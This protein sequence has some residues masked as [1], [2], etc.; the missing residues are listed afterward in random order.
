[1]GALVCPYPA[2]RPKGRCNAPRCRL[3]FFDAERIGRCA[4][5][6]AALGGMTSEEVAAEL[7]ISLVAE[8]GIE[9][10]ASRKFR[11]AVVS[12]GLLSDELR[13]RRGACCSVEGCRVVLR[14]DNLSGTCR[15]HREHPDRPAPDCADG[16]GAQ[17]G[18]PGARCPTCRQRRISDG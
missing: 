4:L 13:A 12:G 3:F 8:A 11:A 16:C 7:G 9:R 5:D 10:R 17:V 6:F 18:T 15:W 2:V 14:L 1:M